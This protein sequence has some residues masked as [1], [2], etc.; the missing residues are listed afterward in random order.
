[1]ILI[2]HRGNISGPVPE[3]E[4]NP[5]YILKALECGYNVEVDVWYKDNKWYTGHDAPQYNVGKLFLQ[6]NNIWCHAKNVDALYSMLCTDIIHFW[7]EN[8]TVTLTSNGYI[9]TYPGKQLTPL[10][11]AVLPELTET[12][13]GLAAGICSDFIERYKA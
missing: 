4:N 13:V 9:W 12:V 11:I 3:Q 1:M 6:N 8:D 5:D 7:H 2:S 10:S